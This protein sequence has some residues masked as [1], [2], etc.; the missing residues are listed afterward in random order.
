MS[1]IAAIVA[2][3]LRSLV[4]AP[5]A[6]IVWTLFLFVAG[7]FFFSSVYQFSAIVATYAGMGQEGALDRL[8]LNDFVIAG[9]FQNLLVLFLFLVPAL[10]MRGF[11]DERRQGTDE[12]LLTAP[13]SPGQIVAGKYLGLLAVALVLILAAGFYVA[14]LTRYGDPEKGPILTGLLG[15]TLA[16]AALVALGF[17]VSSTTKSPV[18][19]AV[20][21]F[22]TFLLLFVVDWPAES[23]S[24]WLQAALHGLSLPGHFE[25]FTRGTVASVDVA[26]FLSLIALG[27]FTARA[28]LASQRWR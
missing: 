24:G 4:Y 15:L 7:W 2:R 25:G 13:V 11:A 6:W 26:Y 22:V 10:T 5:I 28:T 18:V 21:A 23:T 9:L 8:N 17:A 27:L 16:L 20:G 3:E 12:L 14:L 1:R 19:A